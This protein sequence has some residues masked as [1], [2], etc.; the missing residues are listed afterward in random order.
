MC[1]SQKNIFWIYIINHL[2]NICSYSV[3]NLINLLLNNKFIMNKIVL[4]KNVTLISNINDWIKSFNGNNNPAIKTEIVTGLEILIWSGLDIKK[5]I[6]SDYKLDTNFKTCPPFPYLS[7]NK[8]GNY[9]ES[10]ICQDDSNGTYS[11]LECLCI[12]KHKLY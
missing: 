2:T 12:H 9:G 1:V 10:S 6:P 5:N 4:T 7:I 11:L 3:L 8:Y